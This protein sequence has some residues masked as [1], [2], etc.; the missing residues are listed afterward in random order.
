MSRITKQVCSAALVGM[1]VLGGSETA[2]GAASTSGV[3]GSGHPR[4]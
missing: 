3:G 4:G 1:L 2:Y